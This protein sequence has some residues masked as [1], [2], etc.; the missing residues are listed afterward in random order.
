MLQSYLNV[1]FI[2][3]HPLV[4]DVVVTLFF[5]VNN[6]IM[7]AQVIV[8]INTIDYPGYHEGSWS[9]C[10]YFSW[11]SLCKFVFV[12]F[13]DSQYCHFWIIILWYVLCRNL[14]DK[15]W[16][17]HAVHDLLPGKSMTDDRQ[18]CDFRLHIA[19]NKN[20]GCCHQGCWSLPFCCP[21][22]QRDLNSLC[23]L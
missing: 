22:L 20:S 7:F 16:R 9:V 14:C 13:S 3:C 23:L 18:T 8:T 15:K 17:A 19:Q 1:E 21:F 4:V 11:L 12:A 5:I 10:S 2:F 6:K